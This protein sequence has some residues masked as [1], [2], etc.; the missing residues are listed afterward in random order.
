MKK[1]N[2]KSG[3]KPFSAYPSE[4]ENFIKETYSKL[5]EKDR[6]AIQYNMW[7]VPI[8]GLD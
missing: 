6:H 8:I 7:G 3:P 5:P 1:E 4:I 2:S